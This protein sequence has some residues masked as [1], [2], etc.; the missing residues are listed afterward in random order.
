MLK[1]AVNCFLRGPRGYGEP[2]SRGMS[3]RVARLQTR[4]AR[5]REAGKMK[6]SSV[7]HLDIEVG[8]RSKNSVGPEQRFNHFL[9]LD[10]EATCDHKSNP[11]FGP[12]EIIEFPVIKVCSRTFS[13][14]S[15]FHTFVRP[16]ANPILKPFCT[17]LTGMVQEDVDGA[18]TLLE[19]LKRFD[20]WMREEKLVTEMIDATE[21]DDSGVV[22]R[23][24]LG[25]RNFVFVTCGDWDLGKLLPSECARLGIAVPPCFRSWVNLKVSFSNSHGKWARG[26]QHMLDELDLPLQGRPHSGIDDCGNITQILK[27]L[28]EQKRFVYDITATYKE[29]D[30]RGG[31]VSTKNIIQKN[32]FVV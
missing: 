3:K 12:S 22:D 18:P 13:V 6:A 8:R 29:D 25:R 24:Q 21:N 23:T 4:A 32:S 27:A 31:S 28:A 30:T 15:V 2:F 1:T 20:D 9:V 10:F 7:Q 19:T 16:T 26:M 17:Q 14:Q 11:P 5:L